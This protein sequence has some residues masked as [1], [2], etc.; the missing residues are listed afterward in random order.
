[1]GRFSEN[2]PTID[3]YL[4]KAVVTAKGKAMT[5]AVDAARDRMGQQIFASWDVQEL[6]DLVRLVGK[7]ADAVKDDP[8]DTQ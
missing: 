2:K 8:A 6:D 1:V 4:S 5:D 7:F 3:I